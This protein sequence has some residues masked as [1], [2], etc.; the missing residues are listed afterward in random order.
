MMM[1]V[2]IV[3][4]VKWQFQVRVGNISILMKH[5]SMQ[6]EVKFQK[7]HVSDALRTTATVS[8]LS[9]SSVIE[10]INIIG[11]NNI[12]GTQASLADLILE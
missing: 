4:S 7:C 3:M 2:L 6:Q 9:S 5:L 12:S 1:R 10:G 8:R 11:E